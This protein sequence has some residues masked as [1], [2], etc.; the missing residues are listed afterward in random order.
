VGLGEAHGLFHLGGGVAGWIASIAR[1]SAPLSEVKLATT[2][3]VESN[4]MTI[5]SS[6]LSR[7][8][9]LDSRRD[10]MSSIA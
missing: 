1:V 6:A 3:A 4:A 2:S 5:A 8:K 7:W 9:A 10:S